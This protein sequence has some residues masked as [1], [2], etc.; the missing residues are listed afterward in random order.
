[1]Q[2][3]EDLYTTIKPNDLFLVKKGTKKV[4]ASYQVKSRNL[5]A[6]N[7][8]NSGQSIKMKN[9]GN[10]EI[11]K[12]A[13]LKVDLNAKVISTFEE[14]EKISF[15]QQGKTEEWVEMKN[16]ALWK[17][18]KFYQAFLNNDENEVL[19]DLSHFMDMFNRIYWKAALS[20][21]DS[22]LGKF[23][24]MV[25]NYETL[26]KRNL[27][28]APESR[29]YQTPI[30]AHKSAP[31]NASQN[32]FDKALTAKKIT[33]ENQKLLLK[34]F[35]QASN[36]IKSCE[37]KITSDTFNKMLPHDEQFDLSDDFSNLDNVGK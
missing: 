6:S 8:L 22:T 27:E 29:K 10:L 14:N 7:Q 20:V 28:E 15:N 21:D 19:N 16:G 17:G 35:A 31:K 23:E 18:R 2:V 25:D 3:G 9:S 5:D 1:V 11:K 32:A 13:V 24:S 37:G 4:G 34:S 30:N 36:A 33:L 12:G 26:A